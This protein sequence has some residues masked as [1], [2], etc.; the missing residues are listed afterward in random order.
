MYSQ[1]NE[2]MTEILNPPVYVM[3]CE[4]DEKN[5]PFFVKITQL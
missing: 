2:E 4:L 3:Q 1:R 5:Y